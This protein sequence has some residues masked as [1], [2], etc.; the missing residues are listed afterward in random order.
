MSGNEYDDD[1]D[2][3][4][5]D[6]SSVLRQLR[7]EN[8]A[9][10]KQIKEL[11]D[12][13]SSL[14]TQARERSVRDVLTA[15]GLNPKIARFVPENVTAEDEVAAWVE[16]FADVFGSTPSQDASAEPEVSPNQGSLFQELSGIQQNAQVQA[17]GA[18]YSG[19]PDQLAALIQS[20]RTPQELN[21]ILFGSEDGPNVF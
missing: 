15:K 13:L 17:S 2:L 20:A 4:D 1:Y 16:E 21:K 12:Q 3:D 11:Q 14:S 7:K 18:S 5:M 9:K 19:D 6:G 10:E 8:R